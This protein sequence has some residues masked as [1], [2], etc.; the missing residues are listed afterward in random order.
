MIVNEVSKTY[1]GAL[2]E[3]G[4]EKNVLSQIEEEYGILMEL[5]SEDDDFVSFF[6]APVISKEAKKAFV[7]KIFS[8]KLSD[9]F[10][11]FLRVIIDN[12]RQS[13][14]DDIY[15]SF[16]ELIDKAKNRKRVKIV[17]SIKLEKNVIDKIEGTL[18]K[19]LGKDIIVEQKVDESIL[20]GILIEIDDTIIDGTIA[21]SLKVLK[22]R[23]MKRK[24]VSGVEYE[25]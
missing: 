12:N 3:I 21:N 15:R 17:S 22:D 20:G 25:D 13:V 9:E 11:G 23:L 6:N 24:I 19:N 2:L 5:I 14:I 8:G 1:A 18:V 7:D 4:T 10:V 16:I